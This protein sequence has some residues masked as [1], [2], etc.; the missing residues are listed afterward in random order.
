MYLSWGSAEEGRGEGGSVLH[1]SE[2]RNQLLLLSHA[3]M[4]HPNS[5]QS[6]VH[7]ASCQHSDAAPAGKGPGKRVAD[8]ADIRKA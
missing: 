8:G 1:S 2:G 4:S 3:I 7:K 6:G 5:Q